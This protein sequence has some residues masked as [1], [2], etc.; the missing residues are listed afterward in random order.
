MVFEILLELPWAVLEATRAAF[1]Q[2]MLGC[3]CSPPSWKELLLVL[4][5]KE[6]RVTQLQSETRGVALQEAMA[7]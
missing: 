7:K 5:P 1:E 3:G 6:P 2:K 4:I